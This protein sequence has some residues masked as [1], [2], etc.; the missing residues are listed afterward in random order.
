M[1]NENI[2]QIDNDSIGDVY[3]YILLLAILKC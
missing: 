1:T 2:P 3:G